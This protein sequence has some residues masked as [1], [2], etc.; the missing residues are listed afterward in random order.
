M[1]SY[2]AWQAIILFIFSCKIRVWNIILGDSNASSYSLECLAPTSFIF[3][4]VLIISKPLNQEIAFS[5]I[6]RDLFMS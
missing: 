3:N 4:P 2:V 6:K 1:M 5:F